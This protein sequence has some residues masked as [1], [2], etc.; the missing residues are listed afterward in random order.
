[1]SPVIFSYY[2]IR[3][4][5]HCSSKGGVCVIGNVNN[6]VNELNAVL[7]AGVLI[8][9]CVDGNNDVCIVIERELNPTVLVVELVA[10][11]DTLFFL[12]LEVSNVPALELNHRIAVLVEE[13]ENRDTLKV[14]AA[15]GYLYE[16]LVS[17]LISDTLH[18]HF[19]H[20]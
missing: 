17:V 1:M 8:D 18:I 2:V 20:E 3:L 9:I 12:A 4:S 11:D 7:A 19:S 6:S 15:I 13:N 10:S 14:V 5:P 16:K